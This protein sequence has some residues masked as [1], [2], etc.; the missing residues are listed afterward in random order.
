MGIESGYILK[1]SSDNSMEWQ[2][3][4]TEKTCSLPLSWI[5]I[6]AIV[7]AGTSKSAIIISDKENIYFAGK[8]NINGT[9]NPG[10]LYLKWGCL[11]A[12]VSVDNVKVTK[13]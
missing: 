9:G 8:V 6:K 2:V 1:L 4:G 7:N 12:L 3:N 11:Q 5:H 10:G 13:W